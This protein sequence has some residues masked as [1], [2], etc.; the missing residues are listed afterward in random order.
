MP[1]EDPLTPNSECMLDTIEGKGGFA[2]VYR[3]EGAGH[4]FDNARSGQDA[5]SNTLARER[6][7]EY[8]SEKL[9]LDN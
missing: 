6:T 1:S 2:T 5:T 9:V 7:I 4:G 3:Y 8:L